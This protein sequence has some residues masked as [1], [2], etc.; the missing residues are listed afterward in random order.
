MEKKF[1]VFQLPKPGYGGLAYVSGG[2][3]TL[4]EAVKASREHTAKVL[5]STFVMEVR[6]QATVSTT[7]SDVE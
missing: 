1:F 5:Q 6:G 7:W 2:F 3:E 4:K